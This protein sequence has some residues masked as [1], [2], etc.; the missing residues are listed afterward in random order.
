MSIVNNLGLTIL[1]GSCLL[2]ALSFFSKVFSAPL[3]LFV[4]LLNI[5]SSKSVPFPS[6]ILEGVLFL[7]PCIGEVGM[8]GSK[9]ASLRLIGFVSIPPTEPFPFIKETSSILFFCLSNFSLNSFFKVLISLFKDLLECSIF[10]FNLTVCSAILSE[11]SFFV[12]CK[13]SF[14]SFCIVFKNSDCFCKVFSIEIAQVSLKSCWL[15]NSRSLAPAFLLSFA[16]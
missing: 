10:L 16:L 6:L 15:I 2:K 13:F 14:C 4:S 11:S 3:F 7:S 5:F 9:S 12:F 1:I 8:S